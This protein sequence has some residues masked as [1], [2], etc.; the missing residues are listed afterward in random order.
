MLASAAKL[1]PAASESTTAD[2]K[3]IFV[4]TSPETY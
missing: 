3:N 1:T 4:L 2:S